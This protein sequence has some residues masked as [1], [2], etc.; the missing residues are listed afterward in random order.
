M[1]FRTDMTDQKI[2]D[3]KA[4]EQAV[5]GLNQDGIPCKLIHNAKPRMHNTEREST[6]CE[7]VIQLKNGKYDLGLKGQ[8]DDKGRITHYIPV[9]DYYGN[10]VGNQIGY[11]ED[12]RSV[13]NIAHIGKFMRQYSEF[14]TKRR[15]VQ[16]GHEYN[17]RKDK[18]GNL[19]YQLNY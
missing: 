9:F 18:Q 3:L 15:V 12:A 13:G 5:L 7:Y 16:D 10:H 8:K 11:P 17:R 14:A 1:S 2:T 6:M 19:H 4:V